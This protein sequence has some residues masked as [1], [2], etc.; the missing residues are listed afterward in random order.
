MEWHPS[1]VTRTRNRVIGVNVSE[2]L[3]KGKEANLVRVSGEFELSE[4]YCSSDSILL[5]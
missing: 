5:F 3:I 2:F 1:G 4:V